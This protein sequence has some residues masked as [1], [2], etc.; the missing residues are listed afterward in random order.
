LTYIALPLLLA[1]V[2]LIVY[3]ATNNGKVA[4]VA[5]ALFCICSAITVWLFFSHGVVHLGGSR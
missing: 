2:F 3:F 4:P 1:L 5:F